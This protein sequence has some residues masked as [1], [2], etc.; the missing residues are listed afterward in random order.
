MQLGGTVIA[1]LPGA[2]L[3]GVGAA[4]D[5]LGS[6]KALPHAGLQ[7]SGHSEAG[8]GQAHTHTRGPTPMYG[9]GYCDRHGHTAQP[10]WQG[11]RADAA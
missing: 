9:I 10:A 8:D 1:H 7:C 3:V 11:R 6:L 2:L 5:D 4:A